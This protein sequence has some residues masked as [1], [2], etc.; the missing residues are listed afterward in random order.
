MRT[1]FLLFAIAFCIGGLGIQNIEGQ[2]WQALGTGIGAG[3]GDAIST[4]YTILG[5]SGNLYVGGDFNL[6]GG[7]AASNVADWNGTNW[8]AMD[9]G[10][11]FNDSFA[12]VTSMA[13]YNGSLYV[14][15][16]FSDQGYNIAQWDSGWAELGTGIGTG[17]NDTTSLV[18]ALAVY[19][20][21]LYAAGSFDTAGGVAASNIA[22]WDGSQWHSVGMGIGVG[23]PEAEVDALVVTNGKLYAAGYFQTAGGNPASNIAQWDGTSWSN[24]GPGTDKDGVIH[25]MAVYDSDLYIAGSFDSVGNIVANN[26]AKWTGGTTWLPVGGGIDPGDSLA[27]VN[28]L[29]VN[30]GILYAGGFFTSAGGNSA[31]NI[32][33]WDG[34]TWS[35]MGSGVSNTVWSLTNYNGNVYAGG[36]FDSA[37]GHPANK[38]AEWLVPAGIEEVVADNHVSIYPNPSMG[39]LNIMLKNYTGNEHLQIYD[40]RG[41]LVFQEKIT[42]N[43]STIN[44]SSEAKGTYFYR[45]YSEEGNAIS[46]GHFILQ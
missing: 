15:G 45:I 23:D 24:V 13:V 8:A 27:S 21:M 16:V 44:L 35:A 25:A 34:T 14:A 32:A 26:I 41:A 4:V 22:A 30:N 11:G 9:T 43:L 1:K 46:K 39:I 12:Q 33:Q 5:D 19:N 38:I 3:N 2:S 18:F 20:N 42:S 31:N 17:D 10:V 37:G 28:A 40:V 6:A 36:E 7:T 29:I